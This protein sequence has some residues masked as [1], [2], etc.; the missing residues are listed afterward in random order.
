VKFM[1]NSGSVFV[2][3]RAKRPPRR[4]VLFVDDEPSAVR[5]ISRMLRDDGYDVVAAA[6]VKEA[7]AVVTATVV[8]L[9]LV[10]YRLNYDENGLDFARQLARIRPETPFVLVSGY[11][12]TEITVAAVKCGAHDVLDK[13]IRP[14]KLRTAVR[15]ALAHG[16]PQRPEWDALD[17]GLSTAE[18]VAEFVMRVTSA[19]GDPTTLDALAHHVAVSVGT[20]SEWCLLLKIKPRH[21]RDL[22]RL[23]RAVA[24]SGGSASRIPLLLAVHDHRT[25]DNLLKRAGL[26]AMKPS[27]TISPAGFLRRQQFIPFE[28]DVVQALVRLIA[29]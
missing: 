6:S 23:L 25:L 15:A 28:H 16:R 17:S 20:F 14:E 2:G 26:T 12:S 24:R 18:R 29:T 11:L 1:S 7:V 10:D 21:V 22:A 19:A 3:G 8:D 13:P 27:E 4:T 5:I 9:A